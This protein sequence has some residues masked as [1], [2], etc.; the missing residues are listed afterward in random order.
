MAE[1]TTIQIPK[2]LKGELDLIKGHERETYAEVIR[3]LVEKFR[4]DEEA[5]LELAE[6]TIEAAKEAREDLRKGRAYSSK[7]VKEELGL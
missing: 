2:N 3:K 1:T 4:D 5:E 6:E 7:Q